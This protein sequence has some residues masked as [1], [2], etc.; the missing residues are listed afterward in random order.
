MLKVTSDGLIL[1][2]YQ[3]ISGKN[4]SDLIP[5]ATFHIICIRCKTRI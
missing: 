5:I 3:D 1:D 2:Q 4:W